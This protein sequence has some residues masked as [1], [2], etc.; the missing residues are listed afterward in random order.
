MQP[1]VKVAYPPM[2]R[3]ITAAKKKNERIGAKKIWRMVALRCSDGVLYGFDRDSRSAALVTNAAGAGR[4]LH[5]ET[6]GEH[7]DPRCWGRRQTG[8][9]GRNAKKQTIV[10]VARKLA[11]LLLKLWAGGNSTSN[12]ENVRGPFASLDTGRSRVPET[13]WR[14][15]PK[16]SAC[17]SA[18]FF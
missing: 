4:A 3:A 7:G 13:S 5:S 6:F 12:S 1:Q 14:S 15:I 2:L 18:S 11:V 16:K 8:R 10:P 17:T 9:K